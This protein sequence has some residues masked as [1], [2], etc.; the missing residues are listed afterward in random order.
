MDQQ[1]IEAQLSR[2]AFNRSEPFC[3]HCYVR[4]S[5]EIIK[6]PHCPKCGSDDLMRITSEDGPEWGVSWMMAQILEENCTSV[7]ESDLSEHYQE[8]LDE[9]YPTVKICSYEWNQG[10]ALKRLDPI[11]FNLGLSEYIDQELGETLLSFDNGATYFDKSSIE[12]FIAK[13]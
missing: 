9:C 5:S 1:E 6:A 11:A 13:N 3:Y 7:S 2:I 10:E 4:V 8:M 12:E